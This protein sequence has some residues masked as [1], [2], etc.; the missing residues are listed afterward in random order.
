MCLSWTD[1]L[2]WVELLGLETVPVLY[3]G[4][5]PGHEAVQELYKPEFQGDE[6]EGYVVRLAGEFHYKDFRTSVG[7]FVRAGH[8]PEHGG[9]WRNAAV[10]PNRLEQQ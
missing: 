9:H 4:I 10:T 8:T 6:C 5:Y 2:E 7:K 3:R 1:T